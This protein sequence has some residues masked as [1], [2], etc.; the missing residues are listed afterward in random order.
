MEENK[1][2]KKVEGFIL[3]LEGEKDEVFDEKS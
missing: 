1:S 3:V 2:K